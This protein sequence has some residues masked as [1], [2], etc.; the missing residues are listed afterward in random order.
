M[1]EVTTTQVCTRESTGG[2]SYGK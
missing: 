2:H 1:I